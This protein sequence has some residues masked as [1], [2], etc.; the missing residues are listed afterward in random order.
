[1]SA[2][3]IAAKAFKVRFPTDFGRTPNDYGVQKL[4]AAAAHRATQLPAEW[5]GRFVLIYIP[6]GGADV[7]FSCSK[8]DT[9]EVDTAAAT[10]TTFPTLKVGI[11]L[12]AGQLH[13]LFLPT[14]DRPEV[15]FLVYES[16]GAQTFYLALG[17]GV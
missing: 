13:Q 4:A 6:T 14:W 2:S 3:A 17:D 11:P 9:A 16:S 12:P 7:A 10:S 1:M 5:S 8:L 15:A